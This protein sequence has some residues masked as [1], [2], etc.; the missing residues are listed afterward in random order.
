M[1]QLDQTILQKAKA[2]YN[3]F[4]KRKT[5][6]DATINDGLGSIA[7]SNE[8]IK[9]NQNIFSLEITMG[10]VQSQGN[11]GRCWIFAAAALVEKRVAEYL[12]VENF[13]MSKNFLFFYGKLERCNRFYEQIVSTT[14]SSWD[15]PTVKTLLNEPQSDSICKM[16]GSV[17]VQISGRKARKFCSDACRVE[18]WN[19][20]RDQVVKKAVYEFNCPHCGET[21]T[22][23]GNANRKYCS[24]AC[25]IAAR[26]GGGE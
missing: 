18:W 8:R 16:C 26:F 22:A 7:R 3:E 17:I 1:T 2:K 10:D 21:F 5:I 24:H 4:E 11:S 20:H 13:C 15:D 9:E 14:L 19:S 25:Y 6:S 23:Y 12:G